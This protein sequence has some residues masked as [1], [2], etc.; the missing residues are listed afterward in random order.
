MK[1][2]SLAIQHL[3]QGTAL[4]TPRQAMR[5][6]FAIISRIHNIERIAVGPS[7]RD[8]KELRRRYGGRRWRKL[9]GF[10]TVQLPGGMIAMAELH[11][12]E[13]H[14]VGRREMNIK[15]FLK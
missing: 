13:A 5:P 2:S 6:K 3:S 8:I 4:A 14:G 15:R 10:A 12:Y 9:K 11:W 7:I 1:T